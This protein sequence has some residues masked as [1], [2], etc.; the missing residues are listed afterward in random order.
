MKTYENNTPKRVNNMP[1]VNKFRN[2]KS[3]YLTTSKSGSNTSIN[4]SLTTDCKQFKQMS[5][6]ELG[7]EFYKMAIKSRD[8]VMYEV[9]KEICKK[10]EEALLTQN[11]TINE[12]QADCEGMKEKID[13]DNIRINS[14]V[15]DSD[16]Q[17][18]ELEK[19][20]VNST[21][22]IAKLNKKIETL[23]RKEQE[24]KTTIKILE[25]E[26]D[27]FRITVEALK[28]TI[29]E[30]KSANLN[31]TNNLRYRIHYDSQGE[32][33][34]GG[35]DLTNRN[36]T[37]LEQGNKVNHPRKSNISYDDEDDDNDNENVT[38]IQ[39]T[40]Q[41]NN[42][43]S[44]LQELNDFTNFSVIPLE[45][46]TNTIIDE[47]NHTSVSTIP[48][49]IQNMEESDN[50]IYAT[51]TVTKIN[52][53]LS[54]SPT[55]ELRPV[56]R[57]EVI[58]YDEY[59]QKEREKQLTKPDTGN[60]R[61]SR[62]QK[63][64]TNGVFNISP[65]MNSNKNYE[66]SEMHQ[67]S[68]TKEDTN[69]VDNNKIKKMEEEIRLIKQDLHEINGKIKKHDQNQKID[70]TTQTTEQIKKKKIHLIGDSHIRYLAKEVEKNI[71]DNYEVLENFRPGITFQKITE[72]LIPKE[73]NENDIIVLS[74]GTND[75]Y[76]T[77]WNTIQESVA[78]ILQKN[79]KIIPIL[80]P[81]RISHG[82]MNK[83]VVKLNT[84]LKYEYKKFNNPDIIDPQKFIKPWHMAQDG[85]H[86]GRKGKIRL[87]KKIMEKVDEEK[88]DESSENKEEHR[89]QIQTKTYWNKERDGEWRNGVFIPQ[90]HLMGEQYRGWTISKAE[91][92]RLNRNHRSRQNNNRLERQN[93]EHNFSQKDG[94]WENGV[95]GIWE[96]GMFLPRLKQIEK[97]GYSVSNEE[98]PSIQLNIENEFRHVQNSLM[99]NAAKLHQLDKQSQSHS[100]PIQSNATKKKINFLNVTTLPYQL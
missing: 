49:N 86:M 13:N 5:L 53:T 77:E 48:S 23:Q 70:E 73:I 25:E 58:A 92:T 26:K 17:I 60:K 62:P 46:E 51:P 29:D 31:L 20:I 61:K 88:Q 75:L 19:K 42:G 87:A 47:S 76:R 54:V 30:L 8:D 10:Y 50:K 96:N 97:R 22:E 95:Y 59:W 2:V 45:N 72:E 7:D 24:T 40:P 78:T 69:E 11:K 81:P 94:M 6:K 43:T 83:D 9:H 63:G 84:L 21:K 37:Y 16:D 27:E 4:N 85:I 52:H 39:I 35:L 64:T 98:W 33:S 12:L 3:R 66:N 67:K 55:N 79:C 18:A 36:E 44:L 74:A 38:F 82:D 15:E 34:F 71:G 65:V 57:E 89:K 14:I 41:N 99:K 32:E 91:N 90:K 93:E 68:Q 28:G 56:T 80:I 100:N 1:R